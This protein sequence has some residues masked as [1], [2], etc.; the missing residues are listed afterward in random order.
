MIKMQITLSDDLLQQLAYRLPQ[1]FGKGVAPITARMFG[2]AVGYVQG[3][4]QG[5]AMGGPLEG[6]EPIKNP[7]QS[8]ARSIQTR[9]LGP[10]DGEIYTESPYAQRIQDG[11]PLFDMKTV[12]PYGRKS[13]VSKKG[14][15][16]LII[17][18]RWGTPNK[19]GGKRAHFVSFMPKEVYKK[20]KRLDKSYRNKETH[21][22]DNYEGEPIERSEYEWGENGRLKK[23]GNANGMVRMDDET[24]SGGSTY[25]TFRVISAMSLLTRPYG[26]IRKAVPPVDV[27]GAVERTAK[28]KVEEMLQA[29]LEAD[30]GL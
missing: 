16:Y 5:W 4:W 23:E 13:R 30:I 14:I 24:G 1:M 7:S 8:L 6:I 21:L 9:E 22:E 19:E 2:Q 20:A 11:T 15:P 18:F 29:G 26:W 25:F 10:F 12:Y 17:P 27:V 3:V 28:P